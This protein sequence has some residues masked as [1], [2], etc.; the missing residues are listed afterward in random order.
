MKWRT[1]VGEFLR[2]RRARLRPEDVGLAPGGGV[3][4]VPGLRR[5]ELAYLAGISVEYYVRLEQ[6]R[7]P[8]VSD[9]VLDSVARVLRL[10]EDERVHLHRIARHPHRRPRRERPQ[11]VRPGMRQLLHAVGDT[12]AFVFGRRMDI[13]AW[14][15]MACALMIT[16]LGALPQRERNLAR[17]VLLDEDLVRLYPDREFVAKD[18]VGH[19]RVDAGRHPDDAELAALVGELSLKSEEF[20]KHWSMHTVKR[21]SYG[22]KNLAH[23]VVGPMRLQ[24]ETLHLPDDPEQC[25][26]VYT[27]APGSKDE[28]SLRLLALWHAESPSPADAAR[29]TAPA[30]PAAPI[31]PVEPAAPIEPVEPFEIRPRGTS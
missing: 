22:H 30:A 2:S 13:L 7:K 26:T 15:R 28:E 20:R 23:P 19:L 3:R 8:G 10:D 9:A 17:L 4:R 16:E 27:A 29:L 6:G 31:E 21:K 11:E 5:E 12:P 24:F 25:L 1:D 14:N 18:T